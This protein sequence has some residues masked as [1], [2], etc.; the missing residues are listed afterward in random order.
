MRFERKY[1]IKKPLTKVIANFLYCNG[2]KES[3]R[4]RLV[5]SIYY[6]DDKFNLFSEAQNGISS[7]QKLRLRFYDNGNDLEIFEKKKKEGEL[8]YIFYEKK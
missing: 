4:K 1:E 6:D 2:F 5:N 7:R 8:N 3:Y